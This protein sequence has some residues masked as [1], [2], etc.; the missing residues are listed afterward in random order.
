MCALLISGVD[1][2]ANRSHL[3]FW[4]TKRLG[5]APMNAAA[6]LRVYEDVPVVRSTTGGCVLL[7][8]WVAA[9]DAAVKDA[10]APLLG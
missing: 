9:Q 10:F 3:W 6:Y 2:D 7:K 1:R 4:L 8:R 5:L